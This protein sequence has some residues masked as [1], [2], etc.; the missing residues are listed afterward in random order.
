MLYLAYVVN[1]TEVTVVSCTLASLRLGLSSSISKAP[2]EEGGRLRE[3]PDIHA[4][5]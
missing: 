1:H 5:P 2:T 3:Q 4:K